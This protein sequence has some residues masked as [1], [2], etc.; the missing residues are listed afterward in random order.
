M[1]ENSRNKFYRSKRTDHAGNTSSAQYQL[2]LADSTALWKPAVTIVTKLGVTALYA[3]KL[4]S[5]LGVLSTTRKP[6]HTA[7]LAVI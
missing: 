2:T 4:K 6:V 5:H 7:F 1:T 3:A